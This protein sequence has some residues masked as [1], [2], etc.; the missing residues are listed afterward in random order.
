MYGARLSAEQLPGIGA[1]VRRAWDRK[2]S[3]DWT[4]KVRRTLLELRRVASG[5]EVVVLVDQASFGEPELDGL[6]VAPFPELDGRFGGYPPDDDVA[7]EELE[8]A[9]GQGARFLAVAWP[10]FWW[11]THYARWGEHVRSR[12]PCLLENDRIVV[13]DLHSGGGTS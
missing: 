8:R 9:R 5:S 13:F 11:L 12:F 4:R 6:R 7:I 2:T 3:L 1:L 10:A